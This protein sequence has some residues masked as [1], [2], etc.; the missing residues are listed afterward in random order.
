MLIDVFKLFQTLAAGPTKNVLLIGHASMDC[1]LIHA[2]VVIHV[3]KVLSVKSKIIK[4]FV[5]KVFIFYIFN[6]FIFI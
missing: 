6:K 5:E 2:S 1:A 3:I 4:L